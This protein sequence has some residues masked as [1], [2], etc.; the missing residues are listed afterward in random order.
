M[1]SLT[2]YGGAGEIGGNK[3][4][5]E[6]KGAKI[7][8]DFGES[9]SFGEDFFY[10]WLQPRSVNGLEVYFEFGMVPKIPRLYAEGQLEKTDLKYQKPDVDA[11]IISHNHSDHTGHLPFLD[12]GIPIYM[13]HGTHKLLETYQKLYPQFSALEEGMDIRHFESGKTFKVKH[14]EITPVHVD[15]SVPGAYGFILKTSKGN[16]VYTGDFRTHGPRE[17]MT[18]EFVK[19]AKQAKP[20]ALLC[21]GTRMEKETEHNYT[22]KE[23]EGMVSNILSKAGGLVFCYFAMSN[24]DR[25]M[26]IYQAAIK[27]KRK[28]VIGTRMAYVLQ[29]MREK[30]KVLPDVMNDKNIL[31][32]YRMAKSC[33]FC[34]KDYYIWEREFMKKMVTYK[35]LQENQEK[36]V[37][38]LNF[39]G[40]MELV[41]LQPKNADFI[42]SSSEHFLEGED[43]KEEREVWKNWMDHFDI[44]FHKAHCSGHAPKQEIIRVV[45]E[46]NPELLIPMH[47]SAPEEFK[48]IHKNVLIPTKGKKLEL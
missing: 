26:S 28:L 13:G 38:H 29:N 4:L 34:E 48:K 42:Y 9:F 37:M 19:K 17:D 14:L 5:L 16:L 18:A 1:V 23:V 45:K 32:Y 30:I 46:I 27:N 41:Y 11:I 8:L 24:V 36:Y 33:T 15:H 12:K 25:F 2:F 35:D 31:V 40:L 3:I 7:Y 43:N 6:D 20:F 47:T 44:K 21:E 10:D 22:E 39:F